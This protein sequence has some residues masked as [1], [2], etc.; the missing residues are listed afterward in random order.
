[1]A[2]WA[3]FL[4]SG[5]GMWVQRPL[6]DPVLDACADAHG[7]LSYVLYVMIPLHLVAARRRAWELIKNRVR[8]ETGDPRC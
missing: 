6:P 2:C 5:F 3:A 1:M 8:D 4:V 7:A